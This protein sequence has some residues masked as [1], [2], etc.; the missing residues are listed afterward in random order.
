MLGKLLKEQCIVGLL[1]VGNEK[2]YEG[3]SKLLELSLGLWIKQ[4][5]GGQVYCGAWVAG[6]EDNGICSSCS[7]AVVADTYRTKEVFGVRKVGLLFGS[8]QTLSSLGLILALIVRSLL[9]SSSCLLSLLLG[10]TLSFTLLVG[11]SLC[12]GLCL[13]LSGYLSLLALDLGVFGSVPGI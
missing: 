12:V 9:G 6:V 7:L 13:L 8:S 3:I 11:S 10:D 1:G 5:K 4:W 2:R